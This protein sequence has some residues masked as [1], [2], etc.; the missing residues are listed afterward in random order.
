MSMA[1]NSKFPKKAAKTQI[2]FNI[3]DAARMIDTSPS[4]L[5]VWEQLGLST[6]VRSPAGYRLYTLQEIRR[7]KKVQRFKQ[8]KSVSSTAALYLLEDHERPTP[9]K[10]RSSPSMSIPRQLR[11]LRMQ[12]QFTL[13]RAAEKAGISVSFLSCI[14]RGQ[15]NA[16]VAT[17][18]KLAAVYDTN[19]LSFFGE[20]EP[21]RKLVRPADRR[22]LDTEPGLTIEL[23]ALGRSTMEPHLFRIAAGAS[24]GGSYSHEGEEFIYMIRGQLEVWLDELE[25]Y[26]LNPGDSL[27]FSSN[28][29][30]R[31]AN[32][33]DTETVLLWINTP[34]TF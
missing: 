29:T 23:L 33:G 26:L 1:R 30:H 19:V 17:L 16:S 20:P 27:Y 14:E 24:S 8:Q 5:R 3:S 21:A 2:Y 15:A 28:Q 31:W 12:H 9:G 11:N 32:P 25:H 13:S 7:L 34:P 4:T 22:R 18:Q 6:P 10:T